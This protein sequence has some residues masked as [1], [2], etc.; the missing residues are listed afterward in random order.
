[1]CFSSLR[2][3]RRRKPVVSERPLAVGGKNEQSEF[4]CG[5]RSVIQDDQSVIGANRQRI[6]QR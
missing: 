6:W 3:A 1:M 4:V 5:G 2:E